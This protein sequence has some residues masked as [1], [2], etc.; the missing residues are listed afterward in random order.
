MR[1]LKSPDLQFT[2]NVNE[3]WIIHSTVCTCIKCGHIYI[4]HYSKHCTFIYST[5]QQITVNLPR[6][7]YITIGT[8]IYTTLQEIH[9][10][11]LIRGNSYP[12]YRYQSGY[13]LNLHEQNISINF[14][15]DLYIL[16]LSHIHQPG[17][18]PGLQC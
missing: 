7:F 15:Y 9:L 14:L 8:L 6:L 1:Y 13:S 4:L 2:S 16:Y 11:I 3:K 12:P 5:L 10:S 18:S 17:C